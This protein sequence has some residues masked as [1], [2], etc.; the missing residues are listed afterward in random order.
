MKQV[1]AVLIGGLA[2]VGCD[3]GGSGGSAAAGGAMEGAGGAG[4]GG[5]TVDVT[6][7]ASIDIAP[8]SAKLQAGSQKQF[9]ALGNFPG[10]EVRDLT[11]AVEWVSSNPAVVSISNEAGSKGLATV[12]SEEA[13]AIT[14]RIAGIEGVLSFDRTCNYP[15]FGAGFTL[16]EIAPPV[17]W[18]NAYFGDGS[19]STQKDFS[20]QDLYC[21]SAYES[22]RTVVIVFGA[23]WCGSC[24]AFAQR[25][26]ADAPSLAR[27]GSM[28]LYVEF[29]DENYEPAD[30]EYAQRHLSRL[31]GNGPGVRAGD[32]DTEPGGRFFASSGIIRGGLPV[33]A[34]VRTS[35]MRIIY[36]SNGVE[37][38]V[39]LMDVLAEPEKD[40][41]QGDPDE[42]RSNCLPGIDEASEP[43]NTLEQAAPLPVGSLR[44]GVC[45][46]NPDFFRVEEPG[47]WEL[48]LNF[49]HIT[50]DLDMYVW[51]VAEDK[52][53]LDDQ[54][55][56]VG[57]ASLDDNESFQWQGP[58]IVKVLGHDYASAQYLL[59]LRTR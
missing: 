57:S 49:S 53:L 21:D 24:S 4:G 42:Y 59:T 51:D 10:G 41:T 40:W 7:L 19:A 34:V 44:G 12:I 50:G 20:F 43:N 46:P 22:V 8:R 37:G 56:P 29:E 58:A 48:T 17:G 5:V 31:I 28:A 32:L 13:V 15:E 1:L 25:L 52:P 54:G 30:T 26:N 55:Q 11:Q 36:D 14:A 38:P 23:G 2:L 6:G 9:T 47:P 35:D 45:D 3:S 39:R 27:L 16:G 33:I 18:T